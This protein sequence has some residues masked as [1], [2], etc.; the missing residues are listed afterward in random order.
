MVW[1]RTR[2]GQQG[3]GWQEIVSGALASFAIWLMVDWLFF[4]G[5]TW[6]QYINLFLIAG[7]VVGCVEIIRI[8]KWRGAIVL[9]ILATQLLITTWFQTQP[10]HYQQ[11][12]PFLSFLIL[13]GLLPLFGLPNQPTLLV[14]L[15][16]WQLWLRVAPLLFFLA[17]LAT[18]N[19]KNMGQYIDALNF[20]AADLY[21]NVAAAEKLQHYPA[22]T[23]VSE[24]MSGSSDQ[25]DYYFHSYLQAAF[26]KYDKKLSTAEEKAWL[27]AQIPRYLVDHEEVD[28]FALPQDPG[29]ASHIKL[30]FT[31]KARGYGDRDIHTTVYEVQH[32]D[33]LCL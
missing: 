7:L 20:P 33:T 19:Y 30:L 16:T 23:V 10:Q 15:S 13:A 18:V 1:I 12:I 31:V 8:A 28:L 9:S 27:C 3:F 6:T 17:F 24:W 5:N 2:K 22:G 26:I 11:S 21:V 32:L 4:G 25:A 29:F 14:R